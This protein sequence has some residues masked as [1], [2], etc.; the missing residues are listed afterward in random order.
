MMNDESNET[1]SDPRRQSVTL[2]EAG[3]DFRELSVFVRAALDARLGALWDEKLAAWRSQGRV[4]TAML[5]AARD[6]T[7]RGG[8]RYRAAVLAAAYGGVAPGAP[9]GPALELGAALEL[10]QTYLLT[11]D[12][13]IDGDL[14]RRGGPSVHAMLG[15]SLGEALGPPSAVLASD[16]TW[17]MALE[18]VVELGIPAE[19]RLEVL[20]LL[21]RVHEDVVVGQQLD[22]AGEAS[23]VEA[24]HALKT[25]SYTARGPLLLGA[26]LAGATAAELAALE[27]YAA[28]LGVAFQLRDDLLGSFGDPAETGKPVGGDL[29]AGK[30]TAVVVAAEAVL[31]A[32][33]LAALRAV[34]GH[35]A[36]TDD[37]I[38]G[39]TRLL[40]ERG[41]RAAVERRLTALCDEAQERAAA[42]PLSALAC[43]LL[44]GAAAFLRPS[45][46]VAVASAR[47]SA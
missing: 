24:M 10:I 32:G 34:L 1:A 47:S 15:A 41:V 30:R 8:K 27:G 13:W 45:P 9:L 44:A 29:R 5:D 11:Q 31:D 17:G 39:V 7:L 42:L 26:T 3:R 46:A 43:T 4:V 21:L 19:R 36:A 2:S 23:D 33:D 14:T 35:A 25:G 40:A 12:D 37:E 18:R 28:P 20:R 16:F 22:C 6:L 38:A